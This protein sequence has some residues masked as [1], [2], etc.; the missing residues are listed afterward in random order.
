MK[1]QVIRV[2]MTAA[3]AGAGFLIA[4]GATSAQAGELG[5]HPAVLT[6]SDVSALKRGIDPQEFIVSHPARLALRAGHANGEHPAL[7]VQ[8]QAADV[9]ID[10]NSYLVQPPSATRWTV[11]PAARVIA[12]ATL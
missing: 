4:A 12:A 1:S 9:E 3:I 2:A 10:V 6:Q 8:R 7:A 5:Q 11:A